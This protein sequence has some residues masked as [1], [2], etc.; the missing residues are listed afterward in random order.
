MFQYVAKTQT[1][2]CFYTD[3]TVYKVSKQQMR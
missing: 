3:I 1:Q 2:V